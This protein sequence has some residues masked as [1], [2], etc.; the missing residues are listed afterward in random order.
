MTDNFFRQDWETVV[1]EKPKSIG[2]RQNTKDKNTSTIT[3]KKISN[4]DHSDF[5]VHEKV[6]ISLKKSIQQARMSK[7]MSQKQLAVLMNCQSSVI[8]QY[9]NGQAIPNNN[10]ICKL[11]KVLQ[12]KLPRKNKT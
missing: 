2:K 5:I 1:L 11:E 4:E 8:Q 6:S 10:F 12:T 9:E 7:K 3:D